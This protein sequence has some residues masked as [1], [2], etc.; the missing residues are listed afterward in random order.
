[1]LDI[2]KILIAFLAGFFLSLIFG[3]IGQ[4]SVG[5]LFLRAIIF[6]IVFVALAFGVV[7][8]FNTFLQT[9]ESTEDLQ[10]V[11]EQSDNTIGH[12][13]NIV[14]DD[15]LPDSQTAPSFEIISDE[16]RVAEDFTKPIESPVF[17]PTSLDSFSSEK[18]AQY[19][20]VLS[21][22][23][24]STTPVTGHSNSGDL[25]ELDELDEL[26]PSEDSFAVNETEDDDFTDD[27]T[28]GANS[29]SMGVT[30]SVGDN[31]S[32]SNSPISGDPK[33]IAAA[34]STILVND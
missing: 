18:P 21:E 26:L 9:G 14:I 10:N 19:T 6:G 12:T 3:L 16:E 4:V 25:S 29:P 30:M 32:A 1:M 31:S 33:L 13:V 15:D 24:P 7:F 8:V 17:K 2:K 20:E 5:L 28:F 34:V 22:T 11:V 23:K 27:E